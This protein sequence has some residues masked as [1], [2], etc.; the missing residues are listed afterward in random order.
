M[1][2]SPV[3]IRTR[4]SDKHRGN[5]AMLGADTGGHIMCDL[6]NSIVKWEPSDGSPAK[7]TEL[8]C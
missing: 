8:L 7:V 3:S 1:K 5:G 2:P 4:S 6:T